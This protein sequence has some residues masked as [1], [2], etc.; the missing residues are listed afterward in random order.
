MEEI[1]GPGFTYKLPLLT[2]LPNDDM[3]PFAVGPGHPKYYERNED[4][5]SDQS[6]T[7]KSVSNF[8][9]TELM[10]PVRLSSDGI[11]SYKIKAPMNVN[12]KI[13]TYNDVL[14]SVPS[15]NSFEVSKSKDVYSREDLRKLI[16]NL[17]ANDKE[18]E[19]ANLLQSN[20][21]KLQADVEKQPVDLDSAWVIGVIAGVSAAV[22]VGL[23]AIGIGWYT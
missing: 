21:E 1:A 15:D 22:T 2:D 17:D 10:A 16:E 20:S 23:L 11:P 3:P 4:A 14:S 6:D 5:A 13:S 18:N 7:Y 9:D 8:A 12:P 19:I